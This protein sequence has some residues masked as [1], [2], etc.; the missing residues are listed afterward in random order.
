MKISRRCSPCLV[1]TWTNCRSFVLTVCSS[2]NRLWLAMRREFAGKNLSKNN[3]NWQQAYLWKRRCTIAI[4]KL[5]ALANELLMMSNGYNWLHI[6]FSRRVAKFVGKLG[7]ILRS[8]Q[9][10]GELDNQ[11]ANACAEPCGDLFPRWKIP[12]VAANDRKQLGILISNSMKKL[13]CE[14]IWTRMK[15]TM[16]STIKTKLEFDSSDMSPIKSEVMKET[17]DKVP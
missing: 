11:I 8:G 17:S 16:K 5:H 13:N 4:R 6:T 7:T 15:P 14:S 3:N 9:L 10:R 2:R 1:P 12:C